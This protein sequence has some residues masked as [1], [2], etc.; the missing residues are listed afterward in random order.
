MEVTY[1]KKAYNFNLISNFRKKSL[2]QKIR[3]DLLKILILNPDQ[4]EKINKLISEFNFLTSQKY[5]KIDDIFYYSYD[6]DFSNFICNKAS[7]NQE[8][9]NPTMIANHIVN[10]FKRL[11]NKNIIF[12]LHGSHADSMTSH[13]SDID[14]S[15]FLRKSFL[16]NLTQ[17]RADIYA[18]NNF[19]K[20]YDLDSHHAIFLNFEDDKNYYPESFMPLSVLR[21]SITNAKGNS[22]DFQTRY[23]HDLTLDSFFN[24]SNHVLRLS[25]ELSDF[26]SINLKVILSEYFM[27][28]I[29]Y[30]QFCNNHFM[31]KKTIFLDVLN[32]KDKLKKLSAFITCSNIREDWPK[33]NNLNIFGVSTFFIK[34]I[35]EDI[36]YL[37]DEIKKSN[38]YKKVM[39]KIC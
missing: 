6:D 17:T 3:R 22:V 13:Y 30:E 15:I 24:L 35:V 26:N 11:N 10:F 38:N 39:K 9:N 34:N 14:L 8:N 19:I 33:Q 29:L 5:T 12:F 21:K 2:S 28:I 4:T 18:L 37:N 32:N 16:E 25:K 23:S 7:F 20:K 31:D 36:L 27:I 1:L